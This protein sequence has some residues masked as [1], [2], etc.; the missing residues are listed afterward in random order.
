MFD[1]GYS[2]SGW[3]LHCVAALP[4]LLLLGM[5]SFL[6]VL[7]PSD[8]PVAH[9]ALPKPADAD[10]DVLPDTFEMIYG[11]NYLNP[12]SDGDGV[13]DG[14]EFAIRSRPLDPYDNPIIE[15]GIRLAVYQEGLTLKTAIIMFPSP[16][17]FVENFDFVLAYPLYTGD[18]ITGIHL[19]PLTDLLPFMLTQATS[20][21]YQ[22]LV[23]TCYVMDVPMGVL[24]EYA[25][26]S[27]GTAAKFR[28][29]HSISKDVADL[30]LID[31]IPVRLQKFPD[32]GMESIEK[33]YGALTPN[34]PPDWS[35]DQVCNTELEVKE[36]KDGVTT[37]EVTDAS[38]G[39]SEEQTCSSGKCA[40]M[41]G[42]EVISIDPGYL[43]SRVD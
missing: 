28:I 1:N 17:E 24:Y 38:C 18:D 22:G 11:T 4:F 14:V 34:T 40:D 5:I 6:V 42:S 16:I 35:S 9:A 30:N 23:Y 27:M 39:Y 29:D 41:Q 33:Y 25:P 20:A 3:K 37:Y 8:G 10:N 32:Q 31:G 43:E 7:E 13:P 21:S 26:M 12:D 2:R 19:L 36:N 15:P